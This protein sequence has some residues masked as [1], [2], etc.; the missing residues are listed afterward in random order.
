MSSKF[1]GA[2]KAQL[3]LELNRING[4]VLARRWAKT[5]K[6][7]QAL[8]IPAV[9]PADFK[10]RVGDLPQRAN[11]DR[12][13]QNF[14]HVEVFNHRLLQA[15]EHGRRRFGVQRV[16]GGQPFQLALLFLFC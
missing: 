12:V 6:L 10:Q 8:H 5:Q 1:F 3:G 2:S 14:K 16:E 7:P 15:L 13:H 4:A 11:P 9:L